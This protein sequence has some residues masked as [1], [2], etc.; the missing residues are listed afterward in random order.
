MDEKTLRNI[1]IVCSISGL[2]ILFVVSENLELQKTRIGEIGIDDIGKNVRI[3]GIIDSKFVSK[4][5]H[6][7]LRLSDEISDISVVIFSDT[8][9]NLERY[10]TNANKLE[11]NSE[12]CVIGYIDEYEG[13]IEIIG[14][15]I[16]F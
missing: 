10:G 4:N 12:I 15:K 16:E 6:V 11:R 3:C 13:E 5:G 14:K 7:F 1:A 2:V 9:K 8:V